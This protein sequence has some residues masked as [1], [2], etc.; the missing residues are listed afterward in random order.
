MIRIISIIIFLFFINKVFATHNRAG[1]ITYRQIDK[2]TYEV[3]ITTYTYALSMADRDELELNWGDGTKSNVSRVE[4]IT[5]PDDF[6]RN[7]YV[8]RHTYPGPGNY[9]MFMQDDNRNEGIGNIPN[10]VYVSFSLKTWLTISPF[11]GYNNTPIL[12]Y[13]PVDKAALKKVFI[14]NPVA[15]DPD[16]DSLSYKLSVCKGDKGK[17]IVGYTLPEA[18]KYIKIDAITGDLIWDSPQNIGVYNFAI[19]IEEWRG[20]IRIGSLIRDLQVEV[21]ESDNIKPEID[22]IKDTCIIAGNNLSFKVS[23]KDNNNEFITLSAKGG[24]FVTV[25]DTSTFTT[26]EGYGNVSSNYY[27]KTNCNHIRKQPYIVV[28]KAT[29]NNSQVKLT[30]IKSVKINVIAPKI[31]MDSAV[32]KNSSIEIYWTKSSCDN[33]KGYKIYRKEGKE[34][35]TSNYCETGIPAGSQYKLIKTINDINTL[36][37][38]DNDNGY[39][40]V[41]GISYCYRIVA[42]YEDG[43]ESIVSDE[44]CAE[45]NRDLPLMTNVSVENTNQNNGQI[46]VAWSK[47]LELNTVLYPGPYK[48][49]IYRSNSGILNDFILI[50][51]TNSI[52]DTIYYDKNIDTQNKKYFYKISLYQVSPSHRLLIGSPKLSHS[53]YLNLIPNDNKIE[54]NFDDNEPWKNY[55][56]EIYRKNNS[57]G[58]FELIGT[59]NTPSYTDNN[60]SNNKEYCYKV[61][62]IGNYTIDKIISPIINYSQEICGIPED[63]TPPCTPSVEVKSNCEESYNEIIWDKNVLQCSNDI[64]SC[65]IYFSPTLEGDKVLLQEVPFNIDSYQ[66]YPTISMAGCYYVSVIDSFANESA[67]SIKTCVDVCSYYELP[68]VFTPG[69]DGI[70]DLL[71]PYPYKFVEKIEMK[72]YN[73]WGNLVFTTED[74]NINWDGKNE[75]NGKLC[76]DGVYYYICDIYE[77]RLIG[78]DHREIF[79]FINLFGVDN[80]KNKML[81][82]D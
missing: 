79:G 12:L 47:P 63:K 72:I 59:S 65:K 8:G 60:L 32:P 48:Y 7:K 33:A 80:S 74:P 1:E 42:F 62:S 54:I 2:L 68:N 76:P 57:S 53:L 51:S 40:L 19:L 3:T 46:Y 38:V 75:K 15:Y 34:I 11:V 4:K 28:F 24:S 49:L 45:L 22:Q 35:I 31:I 23:A 17:D 18:D 52:N 82:N 9:E 55:Q 61:K 26:V 43:S 41:S 10:S 58:L 81:K 29:D 27:W 39:G 77:N 13:P 50:D 20:G 37:F 21:I 5:L 44:V 70:N 36:T 78:L 6:F 30:D 25:L 66:H 16:G 73:R 56:Y 69:G 64:T 71:V 67:L 14:H